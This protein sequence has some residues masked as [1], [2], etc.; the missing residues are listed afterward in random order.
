MHLGAFSLQS[1]K[2][3][4]VKDLFKSLVSK[5]GVGDGGLAAKIFE[6][7]FLFGQAV[8]R[9]VFQISINH[10]IDSRDKEAS[11]RRDVID[12]FFLSGASFQTL[13]K[14]L[15]NLLVVF[16]REDHGDVYVDSPVDCFFNCR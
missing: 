5:L 7:G 13:D 9:A 8:T 1:G 12:C 6:T 16:N 10:R 11:Y 4:T 14:S 3:F 2:P 15:G